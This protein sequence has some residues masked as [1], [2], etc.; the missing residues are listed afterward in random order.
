MPQPEGT[1]EA[2]SFEAFPSRRRKVKFVRYPKI[3]Y[4]RVRT[5]T[6]ISKPSHDTSQTRNRRGQKTDLGVPCW[7]LEPRKAKRGWR[8]NRV[9]LTWEPERKPE[10]RARPQ[11]HRARSC[12]LTR[13]PSIVGAQESVRSSELENCPSDPPVQGAKKESPLCARPTPHSSPTP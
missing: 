7:K 11:T 10:S 6:Q 3:N 4:T 9:C 13:P 1:W 5:R 12:I 8:T 2:T